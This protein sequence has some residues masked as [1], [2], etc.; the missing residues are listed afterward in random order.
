MMIGFIPAW[1][2]LPARVGPAVETVSNV[3]NAFMSMPIMTP[4]DASAQFAQIQS[5]LGQAAGVAA[6]A[7]NA[8]ATATSANAT[9]VSTNATLTQIV[10]LTTKITGNLKMQTF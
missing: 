3:M 5:G 1:R 2:V 6:A 10:H 4:A 8:A 9:R 7:E